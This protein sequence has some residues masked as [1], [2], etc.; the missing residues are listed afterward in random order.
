MLMERS[1]SDPYAAPPSGREFLN[2]IE[3][4]LNHTKLKVPLLNGKTT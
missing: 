2:A 1:P 3:K 4:Q